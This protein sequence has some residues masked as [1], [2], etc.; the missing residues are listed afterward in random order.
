M[1]LDR[2]AFGLRQAGQMKF[3]LRTAKD[4]SC[5]LCD[6]VVREAQVQ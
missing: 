2:F 5:Y 6:E 1:V 3:D 4:L